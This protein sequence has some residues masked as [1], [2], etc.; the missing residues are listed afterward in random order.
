MG[1]HGPQLSDMRSFQAHSDTR[2]CDAFR[3][4]PRKNQF[5]QEGDVFGST[6]T[7][8]AFLEI[9]LLVRFF[10]AHLQCRQRARLKQDDRD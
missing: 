6:R 5:G 3:Q 8:A 1:D 2:L 9:L 7:V 4:L 10:I